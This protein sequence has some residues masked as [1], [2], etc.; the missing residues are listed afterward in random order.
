MNNVNYVVEMIFHAQGNTEK[1]R[2]NT[3]FK[4]NIMHTLYVKL[5][6]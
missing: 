2:I 3:K 1:E 6:M 5:A 4:Q